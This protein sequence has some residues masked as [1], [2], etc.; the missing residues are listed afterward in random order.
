M[1]AEAPPAPAYAPL[2]WHVLPY[3]SNLRFD[4]NGI[5][6]YG[7]GRSG[8]N[9][10]RFAVERE[11]HGWY[12]YR[13]TERNGEVVFKCKEHVRSKAEGIAYAEN[14]WRDAWQI[15]TPIGGK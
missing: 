10:L 11:L 2:E 13:Y 1:N 14:L 5:L 6:A 3:K 9:R 8:D 12:L 15:E 7:T 4:C